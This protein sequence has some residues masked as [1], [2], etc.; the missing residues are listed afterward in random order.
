MSKG[1]D[2]NELIAATLDAGD[3]GAAALAICSHP[4]SRH[5]SRK[6]VERLYDFGANGVLPEAVDVAMIE[7]LGDLMRL[8]VAQ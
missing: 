4:A 1:I 3:Y 7:V 5:L 2:I 8:E 6:T